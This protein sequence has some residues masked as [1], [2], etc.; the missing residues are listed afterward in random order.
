MSFHSPMVFAPLLLAFLLTTLL[1]ATSAPVTTMTDCKKSPFSGSWVSTDQSV[2]FLSKLEITDICKKITTKRVASNNP[3]AGSLGQE[4]S[5]IYREYRLRPS[6]TCSPVDCVWGKSRGAV[7]EKGTLTAQFRLFFSKRYL[8]LT[9]QKQALLVNW[10]IQYL[11]GK[12][13]PDQ[14]GKT[15]LVRAR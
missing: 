4:N 3:W 6:S 15:L 7:D 5:Y 14:T 12:K 2:P 13:K 8:T 1:P 10:R 9:W 11:G